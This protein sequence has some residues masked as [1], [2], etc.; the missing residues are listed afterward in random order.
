MSYEAQKRYLAKK[1][2]LSVWVDPQKYEAFK[3]KTHKN[4]TSV[5]AEINK[6]VDDYLKHD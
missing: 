2:A 1:K 4:G 5:Y 6:F 3:E